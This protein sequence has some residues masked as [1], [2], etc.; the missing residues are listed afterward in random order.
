MDAASGLA[1]WWWA[2]GIALLVLVVIPVVLLLLFTV[3]RDIREIRVYAD[4]ILEHGVAITGNLDPV[5]ALAETRELVETAT[6]GF[7]HYVGLAARILA[8]RAAS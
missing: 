5:P 7:G 3:L 6:A 1:A 4:D 2:I 8:A